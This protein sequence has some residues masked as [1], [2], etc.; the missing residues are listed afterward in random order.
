MKQTNDPNNIDDKH[1]LSAACFNSCIEWKLNASV[2][3]NYNS[4]KYVINLN[5]I[6]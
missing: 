3:D 1:E 6:I 5:K 2:G 4:L